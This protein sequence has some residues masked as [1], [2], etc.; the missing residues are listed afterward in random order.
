MLEYTNEREL[1]VPAKPLTKIDPES[2]LNFP[3]ARQMLTDPQVT[4]KPRAI[5][6]AWYYSQSIPISVSGFNPMHGCV[7]YPQKS[8]FADWLKAPHKSS[9]KLNFKDQLARE[10][11]F[12]THDYLH[13]WSYQAIQE[14]VP[15]LGFTTK[16]ITRKNIEDFAFCHLVTE[17]V[18][19]VGLDYWV[20]CE[21][22]LDEFCEAGSAFSALTVPYNERHLPEYRRFYPELEVQTPRFFDVLAEFYCTG[23][24]I[25]FDEH[26]IQRSNVVEKWLTKELTYGEKQRE[27]I[28]LWLAYMSDENITYTTEQL[29]AGLFLDTPWR[30]KLVRDIGDM[31][32]EKVKHNKLHKFGK[33]TD[34]KRTWKSPM[35]KR[36]DFRFTNLNELGMDLAEQ[37]E[38]LA[39]GPNADQNFAYFFHQYV[40]QFELASF[41]MPLTGLFKDVVAKKNLAIAQAL[42]KGKKQLE[43]TGSE[44]RDMLV[45]N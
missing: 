3:L 12:S 17:S 45:L 36:P 11:L 20:L 38:H 44:P 27:Y 4:F 33:R 43:R 32:W 40:S 37:G 9:R 23:I 30:K 35:S 29:G 41:E 42:F 31:L 7:L 15:N 8:R 10:V 25:G 24:F 18:A 13:V 14:L 22:T 5:D 2:L 1:N 26:D 16:P 6:Q 28:R 39:K 21:K 34:P 19:T